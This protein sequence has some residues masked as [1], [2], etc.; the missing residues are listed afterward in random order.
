MIRDEDYAESLGLTTYNAYGPRL[1]IA[2]SDF[3][4]EAGGTYLVIGCGSVNVDDV[5]NSAKMLLSI[6]DDGGLGT[7]Y[8][9]Q[10]TMTIYI[11]NDT[12]EYHSAMDFQIFSAS[13][14]TGVVTAGVYF[15]QESA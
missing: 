14:T 6:Q 15:D 10:S 3:T 1:K 9:D 7:L 2:L 13:E 4:P 11:G 5:L 12:N 8:S